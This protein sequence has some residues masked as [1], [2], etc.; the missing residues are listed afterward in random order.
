MGSCRKPRRPT[1]G[2]AADP[3]LV[4]VRAGGHDSRAVFD[5][6]GA[7]P[8]VYI[9]YRRARA[10]ETGSD[11]ACPRSRRSLACL[12]LRH[13]HRS[14]DADARSLDVDGRDPPSRHASIGIGDD[15]DVHPHPPLRRGV[16][17]GQQS[18]AG[19]P[20]DT[21][22]GGVQGPQA[23]AAANAIGARVRRGWCER[24]DGGRP[25][26]YPDE[27]TGLGLTSPEEKRMTKAD[28]VEQVADAIGPRV[29]KKECGLVVNAFLEA[30]KDALARGDGI[31][32]RGFGTFKVRH[33]KARKARNPKTGE[34]V[35]VPA[36]DVP[37]FKPSR[38]LHSRVDRGSGVSGRK[39]PWRPFTSHSL[40]AGAMT[41][42]AVPTA[43]RRG[44]RA[45]R[46]PFCGRPAHQ[47]R[48]RQ[49]CGARLGVP[50]GASASRGA[51]LHPNGASGLHRAPFP[52][53][54]VR[55]GTAP[56]QPLRGTREVWPRRVCWLPALS[57]VRHT[58]P[59]TCAGPGGGCRRCRVGAPPR[60]LRGTRST[61]LA[62]RGPR[63]DG[64]P[65]MPG[66]PC[67]PEAGAATDSAAGL[68]DGH[69]ASVL[70][71]GGST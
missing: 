32:L 71:R 20:L 23:S 22:D 4:D 58:R 50:L 1:M 14:A 24:D 46:P 6:P 27:A 13:G 29:T 54:G 8:R 45:R 70:P 38:H 65:A 39:S 16:P 64:R 28:L 30:V 17:P 62:K 3:E 49:A 41:R 67:T 10:R 47:I 55:G 57:G 68:V 40:A 51:D 43:A 63:W 34:A 60:A 42:P 2:P 7:D 52:F 9:S 31:E 53:A 35:E 44:V 15:G 61:G 36:R 56:R 21:L 33:R 25:V 18:R 26:G 5:A 37:V 48:Q 59:P 12:R 11:G 19:R 66:R 69:G